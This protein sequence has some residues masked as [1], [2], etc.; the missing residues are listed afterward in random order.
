[1][2]D[3]KELAIAK[4]RLSKWIFALDCD[5]KLAAESS[6]RT[7]DEFLFEQGIT[8]IDLTGKQY[9]SGLAVEIIYCESENTNSEKTL[10]TEM[11]SPIILE[12]GT[13]VKSGQVVISQSFKFE[14]KSPSPKKSYVKKE[15]ITKNKAEKKPSKSSSKKLKEEQNG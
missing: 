1:M 5:K 9:D 8:I 10:I 13:V 6:L 2:A 14:K 4:W 12:N 15:T 7:I 11:I 3:L